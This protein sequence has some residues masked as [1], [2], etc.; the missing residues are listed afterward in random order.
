MCEFFGTEKPSNAAV[1][2]VSVP[3]LRLFIAF[4]TLSDKICYQTA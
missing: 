3:H 4:L 2:Q 1:S